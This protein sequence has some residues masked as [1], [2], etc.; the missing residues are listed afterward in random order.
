MEKSILVVDDCEDVR[1]LLSMKLTNMGF[2]VYE[3]SDGLEALEYLKIIPEI[4]IVLMD[5]I[6]PKMGGVELIEIITNKYKDIKLLCISAHF[7]VEDANLFLRLGV[8]E[9]IQKPIR[10]KDLEEKINQYI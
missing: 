7:D 1:I 4:K 9:V 2:E 3:A 6:M 5:I 10:S 8:K